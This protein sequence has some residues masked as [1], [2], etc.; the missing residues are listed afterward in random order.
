MYR[1]VSL[2]FAVS[3][4][5][6][7]FESTGSTGLS[8]DVLDAECMGSAYER[9]A[10]YLDDTAEP[11]DDPVVSAE[12][13][14]ADILLYL[15]GITA[16]CC[17]SPNAEVTLEGSEITVDFVDVTNNEMCDCEC[18]SNF[19]VE[20]ASVDPGAYDI[21]VYYYGSVLGEAAVEVP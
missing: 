13:V 5:A 18:I 6:A 1:N 15:N 20:I 11:A 10:L 3:L 16:N 12:V 14:G 19:T 21:T 17:P 4:L 2:F 9:S 8:A 7:C